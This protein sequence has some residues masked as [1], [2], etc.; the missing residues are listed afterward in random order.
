MANRFYSFLIFFPFLLIALLL[1]ACET[2]SQ[3]GSRP[4]SQPPSEVSLPQSAVQPASSQ[5]LVDDPVHGLETRV[6]ILENQ[7]KSAQPTLKKVDA[8][9]SHFKALSFEL[10]QISQTYKMST[11]T[12]SGIP[13]VSATPLTTEIKKPEVQ[14]PEAKDIKK[15]VEK[16]SSLA[17]DPKVF[18]VTSVRIG[19]QG[20]DI[21][22]IVL[23]TTNVAEIHYDLDNT[24]GLLVI[25]IPKAKWLAT[26]SQNLKKSLMVKSFKGMSDESGSHFV[27]D[28]NQKAK[29]VATARLAPSGNSGH[30]VYIDIAPLR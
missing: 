9:E 24:E 11:G 21:T 6:G 10:D 13:P 2:S 1:S 22:R 14:K 4:L 26:A 16:S 18:A 15:K 12:V 29:V 30:R 28:L 27:I 20:K 8:M 5:I 19:E 25:D 23:D 17:I 7:M 3:A